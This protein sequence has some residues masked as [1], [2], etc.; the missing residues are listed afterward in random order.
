[1]TRALLAGE[2]LVT[3]PCLIQAISPYRFVLLWPLIWRKGQVW[4]LFTSFLYGGQ[5]VPLLVNT[6]FLLY[7][8]FSH[9]RTSS[10]LEKGLIGDAADY[11]WVLFLI[12]SLIVVRE[13][14]T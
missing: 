2:A 10:E 9:R 14:F 7:V 11:A 12:A 6:L 8:D 13:S 4:R 1:M 5:G 3:I